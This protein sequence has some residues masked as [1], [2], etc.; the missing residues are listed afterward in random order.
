[1]SSRTLQT[2]CVSLA[3]AAF[4]GLTDAPAAENDGATPPALRDILK[5]AHAFGADHWIYNDF[6]KAVA[7]ARISNRPIFVTFRC[8]P[9]QACAGFDAEV[10]QGSDSITKLA[11]AKFVAL[12][13][14][15]MKDV[16]L[17]QFQFDH[18]LNWAA[19]FINADGTVYGRYG[20]QSADGPD[21]YN[22][23][24]SL[25][26]AMWRVLALH[27]EY[28]KNA[29]ALAAKR[30]PAKPY[31]T[32]LEMPGLTR[33]EQLS[34]PTA[35]GNCIH[36][37]NIH[38]AEQKEWRD[39][40][41]FTPE[42]LWRYP[43]PDNLGL[44]IDPKD[45]CRIQRV[46]SDS[47]AAK[48]GLQSGDSITQV[49][50]QAIISIA[51][52]QWVLHH[53]PN[54]SAEVQIGFT[55]EV[56]PERTT[57]NLRPGWKKTDISW[58]GSMWSLRPRPGFWGP[59]LTDEELKALSLPASQKAFRI[60]N[61][62]LTNPQGRAASEAGLRRG[63]VIIGLEG[64]PLA[65]TPRQFNAHVRLNYRV[66]DRLPLAVLRRGRRENIS[67]PFVDE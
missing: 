50:G 6:Q 56:R 59:E 18:D 62:D 34:G 9:C 8:V 21:A 4:T 37:H 13:Q 45:G 67:L 10:A 64:K 63:D 31:K 46:T 24:A 39:S 27:A 65:F 22:S 1:M 53:L 11:K 48:A 32:A 14:V 55:R 33:K 23:V 42:L 49:N 54:A 57:L 44:H 29:A 12:R 20:T 51:D 26:K 36:C 47:P 38:D 35:R 41:R 5:D 25:E 30:G 28:P 58:R 61:L 66:G 7:Q 19:M 2:L 16:D 17:S 60:E 3:V 52:I 40:G 43:L 15:E